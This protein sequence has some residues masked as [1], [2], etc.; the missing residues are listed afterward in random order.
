MILEFIG[1]E[2]LTCKKIE[3]PA[4]TMTQMER[5]RRTPIEHKIVGHSTTQMRP[6]F[7]L[8]RR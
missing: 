3:I 5:D 2:R 1:R 7:P 6:Y 4:W 8:R